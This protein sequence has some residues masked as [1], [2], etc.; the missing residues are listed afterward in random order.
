MAQGWKAFTP[1]EVDTRLCQ[2]RTWCHGRGGQCTNVATSEHRLCTSHEK[3]LTGK[4][5]AHGFVT[6]PIPA[7]K[8]QEFE[9]FALQLARSTE[10]STFAQPAPRSRADLPGKRCLVDVEISGRE[11][12]ISKS[13]RLRYLRMK[14]RQG[15]H[16]PDKRPFQERLQQSRLVRPASSTSSS[17]SDSSSD[18]ESTARSCGHAQRSAERASRARACAER[19]RGLL[20]L[21]SQNAVSR[22][23]PEGLKC[24]W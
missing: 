14:E 13:K 10:R 23:G 1:K 24:I 17:S 20:S 22:L 5:L 18:S 8:L 21:G 2:A 9:V 11:D 4:G 16:G 19:I 12:E 15:N 7:S 3:Q 6:G